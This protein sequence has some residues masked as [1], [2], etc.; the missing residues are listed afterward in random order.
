MKKKNY[1]HIEEQIAKE[2]QQSFENV[3][4]PEPSQE[5]FNELRNAVEK[6]K[7][8]RKKIV[9]WRSITAIASA[10]CMIA[11]IIIPTVIM[12]NKN[13]NPP[14]QPPIYYGKAEATKVVH[15]LEETENI[16]A[17]NFPKYNFIFDEL[18]ITLSTGY[19][20][21]TN[22]QL[23]SLEIKGNEIAIPYTNVEINIIAN[24]YFTFDE[25]VLYT[26]NAEHTITNNYELYK[27]VQEDSFVQNMYGYII[28]E[29]HEIYIHFDVINETLFDKF[30]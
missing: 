16:I 3:D 4:I 9:I 23:L 21:P 17:T 20:N 14:T 30:I 13:D 29:N 8:K 5:S 27:K 18:N 11:L 6:N 7:P 10:M 24:E 1:K 19:Y 22:N 12:L 26:D 25:N 15:T 28:F 2:F